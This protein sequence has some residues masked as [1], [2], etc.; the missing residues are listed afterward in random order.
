MRC[1]PEVS[2]EVRPEVSP[3]VRPEVRTPKWYPEFRSVLKINAHHTALQVVLV[4]VIFLVQ[5][6][7]Y[8]AVSNM[9]EKE[10]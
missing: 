9:V 10:N 2:P 5:Y 7:D 4:I 6:R 8:S 1:Y 3:E